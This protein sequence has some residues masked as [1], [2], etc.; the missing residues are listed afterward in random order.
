[1][2]FLRL[3]D[4]Q[5]LNIVLEDGV[6]VLQAGYHFVNFNKYFNAL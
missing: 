5:R 3:W 4:G 2:N 6:A 1:M